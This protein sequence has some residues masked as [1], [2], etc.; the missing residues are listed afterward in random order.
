VGEVIS[1][2][3]SDANVAATLDLSLTAPASTSTQTTAWAEVDIGWSS[4]DGTI[5]GGWPA[6]TRGATINV[7]F[8][9]A[10]LAIGVNQGTGHLDANGVRSDGSLFFKTSSHPINA[11][12]GSL[13]IGVGE[14]ADTINVG[15]EATIVT[16]PTG[17]GAV[18]STIQG[19][20]TADGGWGGLGGGGGSPGENGA[21]GADAPDSGNGLGGAGGGGGLG[22]AGANGGGSGGAGGKGGAGHAVVA[23]EQ[24]LYQGV[25]EIYAAQ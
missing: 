7:T 14:F 18:F 13:A 4:A 11:P 6:W 20:L 17:S 9:D 16:D 12:S 25:I 2:Q 19:N 21:D 1:G 15:D 3:S 23:T 22:G 5:N 10:T 8:G 24:G